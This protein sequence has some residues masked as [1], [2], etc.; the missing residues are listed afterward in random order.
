MPDN[1]E[2]L[3]RILLLEHQVLQNKTKISTK[4]I[5]I[6]SILISQF[7]C[8]FVDK[9]DGAKLLSGDLTALLGVF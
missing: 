8:K 4:T 1:S 2:L 5:V 9:I 6:G 7:L 3:N